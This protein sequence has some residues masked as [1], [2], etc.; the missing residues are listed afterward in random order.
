MQRRSS[1]KPKAIRHNYLGQEFPL[2][3]KASLVYLSLVAAILLNL[4]LL[5]DMALTLRPDFVA[6]TLLYWSIHQQ[7]HV[8]MS[9]SFIMGLIMDVID[10]SIMGQHALA[11]CLMT[12]FALL[13]HRRLRIFNIFRQIPAILWML[14]V[15]QIVI[16]LTG[17]LTGTYSAQWHVLLPSATGA[18]TWPLI[19]IVLGSLRKQRSDSDEI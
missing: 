18:L 2:P 13:L 1:S 7:Q 10:A 11:Y 6:L 17:T 12:Y 8:G 16:F 4:L 14:L 3:V 19:C 5:Q 15:A 9:I